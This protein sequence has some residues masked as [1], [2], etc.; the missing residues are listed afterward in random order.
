M[1]K[2]QDMKKIK[3]QNLR[4]KAIEIEEEKIARNEMK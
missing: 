4:R 1:R 3:K 2:F